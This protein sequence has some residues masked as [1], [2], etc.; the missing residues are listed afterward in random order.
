MAQEVVVFGD[1]LSDMGQNNWNHKA[2]YLKNNGQYH[3]LY[4]EHL[5]NALGSQLTPS[6]QNG[7]NYAFSGGVI[8]GKNNARTPIQSH[9]AVEKQVDH[10]LNTAVKKDAMHILWAGGNDMAAILAQAITKKTPEEKQAYVLA[11]MQEMTQTMAM[12]WQKLKQAGVTQVIAPTIPNITYTPEFFNQL[13]LTAGNMI[14]QKSLG[15]I[16]K[17]DFITI[18]NHAAKELSAQPTKNAQDLEK[19][20]LQVFE[21][22][23]KDFYKSR[24]S[25]TQ[26]GLSKAGYDAK[27]IAKALLTAYKKITQEALKVTHLVNANITTALNQVGG[28]IVRVDADGLVK[29]MIS[30]PLRYGIENTTAP[31]CEGSTADPKTPACNPADQAVANKRLFADSF[32]PGTKAH[33][34][35]ADYILNVVQTPKQMG[36]LIPMLQ[37]QDDVV[38]DFTRQQS[39]QNRLTPQ[40]AHTLGSVISYQKQKEGDSLHIGAKV[41]FDPHWQWAVFANTQQQNTQN[42]LVNIKTRNRALS[43]ALRYD[44]QHWYLGSAAQLNLTKFD[45]QRMTH[46]GESSHPQSAHSNTNSLGFSVFGGYEWQFNNWDFTL[47]ADLNKTKTN[48]GAFG[49]ENADITQMEFAVDTLHSLKSGIGFDLRYKSQQWQPYLTTRWV[50]EWNNEEKNIKATLNGSAFLTA[51]QQDKSWVNVMAGLQFKPI[52]SSFY[53]NLGLNKDIGRQDKLSDT[54]FQAVIGVTF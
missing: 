40:T 24:W 14:S 10:Y 54:N 31:A 18:F 11:S 12:Q 52:D 50:K 1:S 43:T 51:I 9:L 3:W 23:A 30:D 4:N 27:G 45:T 42:G 44:A 39:N 35:M 21:K 19:Y 7:T 17:N 28:N 47:L 41:Q 25:I 8:V 2:A 49:E 36:I 22:S 29:E 48:I 33:K 37:Q 13:G 46:I 5:A 32:H 20:R 38:S 16:N 6:T 53:I 26:W 15:F 34:A